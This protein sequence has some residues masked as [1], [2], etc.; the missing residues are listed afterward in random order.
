MKI[1]QSFFFILIITISTFGQNPDN[2][3]KLITYE[4]FGE[5][6]SLALNWINTDSKN[7]EAYL[8]CAKVYLAIKSDSASSLK[9]IDTAELYINK[10]LQVNPEFPY[11]YAAKISI[12][13]LKKDLSAINDL[14]DKA[15]D[16][17]KR[18]DA[19]VYIELAEALLR[20][21]ENVDKNKFKEFIDDAIKYD[22]NNYKIYLLLGDF[23][24]FQP[25]MTSDAVSNFQ[26][27]I[28]KD[29]IKSL[30]AYIQKAIV[31]DN[32]DNFQEAYNQYLRAIKIAPDFPVAYQKLAQMFYRAKDWVRADTTYSLF[33]KY[34]EQSSKTLKNSVSYAFK[35]KNYNHVIEVSNKILQNEPKE[36]QFIKYISLSYGALGDTTKSLEMLKQYLEKAPQT[37]ITYQDYETEAKLLAKTPGNDS[38]IVIAYTKAFAKDSTKTEYLSEIGAIYHKQSKWKEAQAALWPRVF[39]YRDG[40]FYDYIRL[41]RA[42]FFDTL[43][44]QAKSTYDSMAARFPASY[45]P[46]LQLANV[47]IRIDGNPQTGFAKEAFEKFVTLAPEKDKPKLKK[48]LI[49]AYQYLGNYYF[50]NPEKEKGKEQYQKAREQFKSIIE[51]DPENEKAAKFLELIK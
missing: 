27:A 20:A 11:L 2:I 34:S 39:K 9:N 30:N 44:Q 18:K 22:K 10:G 19:R 35:A 29:K 51:L 1:Y 5:A 31:Y 41:G 13:I 36:F 32:V 47:L 4:K 40:I 33:L 21:G 43:Y 26:T 16:I 37:D 25:G 14:I 12:A 46:Y 17:A 8:S 28:D 38:L 45:V 24:N 3:E 42:Y 48:D 49:L 15:K 7:P 50:N 23:Y 6:R